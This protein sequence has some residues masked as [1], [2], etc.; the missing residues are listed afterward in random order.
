MSEAGRQGKQE[1][2]REASF[3]VSSSLPTLVLE[4][5]PAFPLQPPPA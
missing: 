1:A 4:V 5:P 2:R 3:L